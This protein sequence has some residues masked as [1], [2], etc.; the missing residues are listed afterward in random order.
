M[1]NKSGS[2]GVI[3]LPKGGG[4]LQG[5]GEKFSPDLFTGTGNFTV[6]IA[7]PPGRNGFQPQLNLVYSTGN[8]N[9][10]F[11]L[12]WSL[13]I[14]GV[15]RKTSKG[16]PRYEDAHDVF[17]LSG[18]EDLVPVE[19]PSDTTT[20]YRPR[21]EGL[22]ARILHHRDARDNYWEVRSKDGLVSLYGTPHPSQD[23]PDWSDSSVVRDPDPFKQDHIF[24][25]K[26]TETRDPFGNRIQYEYTRD[27]GEQ[28]AHKWDQPLLERICYADYSDD[29][30]QTR[31]LVSV[32]FVYEDR[33]DPF[34]EYRAGFENRTTKRCRR[35]IVQTHAGQ[36]RSV[37]EYGF[38][39]END[40]RNRVS[41][42]KRV[43]VTGF[44][45]NG[46]PVSELPP[47]EFGYTTFEPERRKFEALSGSLPASSL[48]NPDVEM[49]DMFGNGLPDILEMNGT[50]RYWRNLGEGKFDLPRQ[51]QDAPGGLRLAD[52]GVQ[53]IDAN[54]DGR[55]DLLVTR[56]GL[57]GYFPLQ[58][59]GQWN[60]KS[61]QR[62]QMA[63][64]FNLEDPEVRLVDLDGDG[65]TDAIRSGTRLEC[66]FNDPHAG[67]NGTRWV[68]RKAPE[69]FPNVN[70]SDPRVK[71][72]DMSGD[73]LQDIVLVYDGNVE[74]WPALG[75]GEWGKRIH[76]HDS[77]RFPYGYDPRRILLGDVDGDGL[78]D[79]VFVD[80]GKVTLWINQSGNGWSE[81]IEIDGTPPMSDMDSVRLA[82]IKGS[83]V[84]GVLWSTD[85]NG[86]ERRTM[87]FLDFTAGL[88]PYLL[89]LMD[90]H[91][92]ALTKVQYVPSTRFYLADEKERKARWR[93]PLPFPVQTVARVEVIDEISG[94]KLTTEYRYHHGYWD[95]AEREF[96]G[97][98][99]VEQFDTETFDDYNGAGLH[100]GAMWFTS[101]D[102]R[103][104]SPPTLT[105]S[106]FHQGP[107]GEEFGEW[108]ELDYAGEYWSGDPQILKHT[109]SVNVFL[110]TLTTRRA[111]RD[112]LRT[113]R[114]SLLRTEL[115]ALDGGERQDRP[116]TV[117]E[118]AY[119]LREEAV[120]G[121]SEQDRPQIF[122]SHPTA[123]RTTQW[124]RGDDPMAQ[125][126]F[127]GDYNE[128]GQARS[129]ISIAVPRGRKFLEALEPE[130]PAP[131]PYL[132]THTR[133]DY[134]KPDD[135]DIYIV[136][137]VART[138]TYE[139]PND[140]RDD[141]FTLAGK[142]ASNALDDPHHIIGQTLNFYDGD[143]FVG[144]RFGEIG[145]YGALMRTETLVLTESILND[146]YGS[147]RP[148][149]LTSE[150][151]VNWSADY[152]QEFRDHLPPLA[153]YTFHAGDAAYA[154]G[155]YA[156]TERRRYDFHT[157][158]GP[159]HGLVVAQRDVL[160]RDTTI[161]FDAPYYLLPFRVIDPAGLT[162]TAVYN[163]RVM[164]PALMTD[165][166]GNQTE[167]QF[168]PMGL[169]KETWVKGNPNRAE[170]DR[171]RPGARMEYDFLGFQTDRRPVFVRTIR[172]VHHD[173][174]AD[175]PL[176]E[177][178]E[179][180]ETR[181]YSDGFGRLLQTRAQGEEVRF[182][183][184]VFGGGESVLPA[185]QSTGTGGDVIGKPNTNPV[186]SNVIVS[187]WQTY[188]NKGR[189]VEK[190]EPFFD[191]GWEYDPPQD[192]QIGQKATIH[193]DPRDQMIR[194]VNPDG[195]EQRV[196]YG[197][198]IDLSDPEKFAPTPWEAY[199]YD[200]NDNAGRTHAAG[201]VGYQ[202]HWNTPSS[203]AIDALGRTVKTVARN[204]ANPGDWLI[205]QSTYDIQGNLLT[206]TDALGR[207]A[208]K[209]V[210]DLAKHTLWIESIDAGIRRT[211]LDAMGSTIE[212]R[213]SKGA[214]VLH[215]YDRLNRP[216]RLWA[217]DGA[218]EQITLREQLIYGDD[219]SLN[220][221]AQSN[222]RGKLYQHYDEAGLLTFAAYD[223][224]GSLLEKI[225][226]V[227]GDAAILTAFDPPL[228]KG[229]V[230]AF[231]VN[232][233]AAKANAVLDPTEYRTSTS[234]DGLN[235][236][237]SLH[238]P[239]DVENERKELRPHYSRAGAL[240]SVALDG[241]TYVE[242]IAYNAKGQRVLITYGNQV[243]ARYAYD[244][245][246]VRLVRLRAERFD[247]PGALTYHPTGAPLQDFAYD[248]DL[249][250]NILKIHDRTPNSGL[251]ALPD[252]LD[253]A[254][255]YDP[256]YR[257]LSA[258]GRECDVQPP[259]PPWE[260]AAKCMDLT[261]TR[262]YTEEYSYDPV[263]N[264][265]RLRHSA[266]PK[267]GF[268]RDFA[269]AAGNNRLTTMTTGAA[270][271]HKY[272]Y[273]NNGN[274]VEENTERHFEWDH[275]GRM[276]A[277][278]AQSGNAG[279]SVY[280]HYLYDAAGQRVTKLVRRQGGAYEVTIYIDGLFE[281]HRRVD[282]P[283]QKHAGQEQAAGSQRRKA[284]AGRPAK[285]KPG[286]GKPGETLENN[287]LH[288]MDDQSRIAMMRVGDAFPD[289]GAPNVKVKYHL[290][291][292]L[293]S[294]NVVI[295][296]PTPA[297]NDFI[298]REEYTPY[299]ETCFGSFA[300]KRYRFTGKERDEESGL[301]YHGARY[302]APW[303]V[304][305]VSCDP[306]GMVDGI[307][308]FQYARH[309]PNLLVDPTGFEAKEKETSGDQP[310]SQLA[311]DMIHAALPT[312]EKTLDVGGSM[313]RE[314]GN[315]RKEY[316]DEA[317]KLSKQWKGLLEY[318]K[319]RGIGNLSRELV[320]D[321]GKQAYRSRKWLQSDIR[322]KTSPELL[323]LVKVFDRLR[324]G[325]PSYPALRQTRGPL[326]ILRSAGRTNAMVNRL[327]KAAVPVGKGMEFVGKGLKGLS[328][329]SAG[330]GVV[331]VGTGAT[332]IMEGK[333]VEGVTDIISGATKVGVTVA[334]AGGGLLVAGAGSAAIGGVG[335][336][337]ETVRAV[338]EGRETPYDSA[339]QWHSEWMANTINWVRGD[340]K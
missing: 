202:S 17:I 233:G 162:T 315:L 40:P 270:P 248:Y 331:E 184:E 28:D 53:M 309:N 151:S 199:T 73:G 134:A 161:E 19:Q 196:I 133:T 60:R 243:M 305:W 87:W 255:T 188:D 74:Y 112:G 150:G 93:T 181:E 5:M 308:L 290:G 293:G 68:E 126:T 140:G 114:G 33:L 147:Q 116:Y 249:A 128:Y 338:Q 321:V 51:M 319:N 329:L 148:P 66:F 69:V 11:G 218:G 306:K 230:Q 42:L 135:V 3:S 10:P 63:P 271:P 58:F 101:V 16:V 212:G 180:I 143:E 57:A 171:G 225:R 186:N 295:G 95:G 37:R 35:I 297:A 67:W 97:F 262:A 56:D 46:Q 121:S 274:L 178:D 164:Q 89:N 312:I 82:D 311:H 269:L 328:V 153:G 163:Y 294:S 337:V 55:S 20:R 327:G 61:F 265:S 307:N 90:N 110:K 223:F 18:A 177:R 256:L 185:L 85:A 235:R 75:R 194:T 14:P 210:Y 236:I 289:D 190:Y 234:Y 324:G 322:G 292:H 282:L 159:A 118:S 209:H 239:Q 240:E 203:I 64:S 220:L 13:S 304:R 2:S 310:G 44:D 8:G 6:P 211:V 175:I 45:D 287:T 303:L 136:D 213:D 206:V 26:L 99:M 149:Y 91:M 179:S 168:S 252:R 283:G 25:W 261:R 92:G 80:H 12:G 123:Q 224:K 272:A 141:L 231:R 226:Q 299:G 65:I 9:G 39:Y 158:G 156:M 318:V 167:F 208:F 115:Y 36:N 21:T 286:Q 263:G 71:L 27:S 336:A 79:I 285:P 257:L 326:D 276:R 77:P 300:K 32:V 251:P 221:P 214:L 187:G 50:V 254:F 216:A 266:G 102:Q 4:A 34:S 47:L 109:E 258:T 191:A 124:E 340:K 275:S 113:L 160:G 198:P 176:P 268:T 155:Y 127:S 246:T 43:E 260:E 316:A 273:D 217:R 131:E 245:K 122:F 278:R 195:S 78:A 259:K 215:A 253:R 301:Y 170:G 70:F 24:S 277:Y 81:P 332:K 241:E 1:A 222:L 83:G 264:M 98:G 330:A 103:Y 302:Y 137:R 165:P 219:P 59:N 138:S 169:L 314:A 154:G 94:G 48:S 325:R 100:G 120:R 229:Q 117:T 284:P 172:Q 72:G 23:L 247:K 250:G 104:F 205:A 237:K 106:W 333:V 339:V 204:G 197:A 76:M 242:R 105:K 152:P 227:I 119:G 88:K 145:A 107:V 49:V 320:E 279:P 125:F 207:I 200:A 166:N 30:G 52:S 201:L 7:L 183:N 62:Y 244:P 108:E 96:R 296:G 111:K 38:H 192:R 146:A 193:Y 334:T 317:A 84:S 281:H 144:L 157:Q 189:V 41:L 29:Q 182:G 298:N 22:F 232:W 130:A 173:T 129:Q 280:A 132:S 238:Y 291:D 15:S 313:L 174:E 323:R 142:I 86:L 139:I 335:L 54:G 288:V 228:P 267:G 31:Y